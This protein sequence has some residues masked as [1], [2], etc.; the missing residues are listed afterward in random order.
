[1][2]FAV[3]ASYDGDDEKDESNGDGNSSLTRVSFAVLASYDS[4][5]EKDESNG[6]GNSSLTRVSFAV[7]ASYD[8]D[9]D[10]AL[11]EDCNKHNHSH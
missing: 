2:S 1:V 8:D 11:E 9:R 6:D 3:L 5:D 4:D 7:L 10:D